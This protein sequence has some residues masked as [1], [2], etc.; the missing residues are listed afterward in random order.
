M[1]ESYWIGLLD[2]PDEAIEKAVNRALR[3]CKFMPAPAELRALSP[4]SPDALA[5]PPWEDPFRGVKRSPAPGIPTHQ[6]LI[7]GWFAMERKLAKTE[8]DARI[9]AQGFE[10]EARRLVE[11]S[12]PW[13]A[14]RKGYGDAWYEAMKAGCEKRHWAERRR[15]LETKVRTNKSLAEKPIDIGFAPSLVGGLPVRAEPDRRLPREPEEREET[16]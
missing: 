11:K 3:E 7:D 13:K 12:E 8:T 5:L 15:E 1:L 14:A 2:L 10:A 6:E 4:K 9:R 16:T